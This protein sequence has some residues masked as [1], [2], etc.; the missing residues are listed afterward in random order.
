MSRIN[1]GASFYYRILTILSLLNIPLLQSKI[2]CRLRIVRAL[3]QQWFGQYLLPD[4]PN[5]DW[6]VEGLTSFFTGTFS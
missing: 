4:T 5:D 2:Q 6:L 3:A 1:F